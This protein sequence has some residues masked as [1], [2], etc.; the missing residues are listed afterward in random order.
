MGVLTGGA[1]AGPSYSTGAAPPARGAHGSAKYSSPIYYIWLCVCNAR[2]LRVNS[3][4]WQIDT[5]TE[6]ER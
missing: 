5:C 6:T 2:K 3:G 1:T 4:F